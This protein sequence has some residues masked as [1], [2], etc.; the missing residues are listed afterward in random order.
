MQIE[1]I[2]T[3]NNTLKFMKMSGDFNPIHHND[4]YAIRNLYGQTIVHG[5][6]ILI[7]FLKLYLKNKNI[8]IDELNCIFFKPVFYN[9]KIFYSFTKENNKIFVNVIDI[10][11]NTLC[12]FSFQYIKSK[13]KEKKIL[14]SNLKILKKP[15]EHNDKY[16]IKNINSKKLFKFNKHSNY[17]FIMNFIMNISKIIGM[18]VPGKKSLFYK[19]SIIKN[20]KFIKKPYYKIDNFE[21]KIKLLNTKY[22]AGYYVAKSKSFLLPN[23]NNL[24][25]S[26]KIKKII[27][28]NNIFNNKKVL[29]IGGSRGIGF[30][31]TQFLSLGGSNITTTYSKYK[32][33]LLNFKKNNSL[34][35]LKICK[36]DIN[37]KQSL[38]NFIKKFNFIFYFATPKILKNMHVKFDND[39]YNELS[40]Y[41]IQSIKYILSNVKKET[42]IFIPSTIYLNNKNIYYKEYIKAKFELENFCKQKK[43]LK[44]NVHIYISRLKEFST[45]QNFNIQNINQ[46]N[47][48]N[49][50]FNILKI[51]F[52]NAKK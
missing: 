34:S 11:K 3:K 21:K 22:F 26:N 38:S 41:Y 23:F 30:M 16:L 51:F 18:Y 40:K 32:N 36:L 25:Y 37:N 42:Y 7:Y 5:A 50:L 47:D 33:D 9:R 48:L 2:F 8:V 45:D 27:N 49:Y 44:N 39:Y 31:T 4:I 1:Q 19:L 15:Y 10:K 24:D 20:K 14:Y 43:H 13:I 12:S 35:K 6:L 17:N 52:N 46:V 28:K 29:I